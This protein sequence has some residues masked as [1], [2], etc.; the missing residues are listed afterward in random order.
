MRVAGSG[1]YGYP[2]GPDCDDSDDDVHPGADDEP[3]DGVDRDCGGHD[4]HVDDG[5]EQDE[6]AGD[7]DV[8][9]GSSPR[10]GPGGRTACAVADSGLSALALVA[11]LLAVSIRRRSYLR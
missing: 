11:G 4:A 9:G 2:G 6:D 1:S 5:D 10:G 3:D 8:D 7:H